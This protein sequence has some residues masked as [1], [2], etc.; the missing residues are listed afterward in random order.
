MANKIVVMSKMA[1]KFL[2]NI[3]N[4]PDEKIVLIEH[5][6]PDIQFSREQSKKEYR[7]ENKKV[8]THIWFS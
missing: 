2:I 7:L 5:G 1:I 4:V 3:Y 8:L 6:V